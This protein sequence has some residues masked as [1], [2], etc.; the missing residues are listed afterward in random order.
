MS[1]RTRHWATLALLLAAVGCT[2]DDQRVDS[3]DMDRIRQRREA[4]PA[5]GLAQ[6][7]SG[8][9]AF[10]DQSYE[11]ALA[12]YRKASELMPD[13]AAS[14]YGV[15]MAEGALGRHKEAE[16]AMQRV[17]RLAPGASLIHV[18][19]TSGAAQ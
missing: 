9:V 18:P 11:A 12:H 3:V 19:D 4:F 14:W 2:P 16:A 17:R 6:L 1:F 7:D 10:G 8:N 13:N 5:D 15:S